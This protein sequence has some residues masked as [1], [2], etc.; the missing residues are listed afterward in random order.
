[1][2]CVD[3]WTGRAKTGV[4]AKSLPKA[5]DPMQSSRYQ[6]HLR[7]LLRPSW[8]HSIHRLRQRRAVQMT[9]IDEHLH[10]H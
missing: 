8:R 4:H 5:S 6:S 7:D 3:F 9:A 1:M 2:T 10:R